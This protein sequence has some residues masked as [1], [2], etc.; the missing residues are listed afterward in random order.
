MLGKN[1][2]MR[3]SR[4]YD[5]SKGV[6]QLPN[7]SSTPITHTGT[8]D[9]S[10]SIALHHVL[11][12]PHF[13]Y[14]LPSISKFVK[15]L[16]CCVT[17]SPQFCV[18]MT[19]WVGIMGIGRQRNGPYHL[20]SSSLHTPAQWAFKSFTNNVISSCN[21]SVST[22]ISIKK[23]FGIKG[24]VIFLCQDWKIYIF[25]LLI[26][27]CLTVI[28]VPKLN[29]N[30]SHFPSHAPLNPPLLSIW[31]TWMFGGHFLHKPT[32]VNDTFSPLL[33]TYTCHLGLS[34]AFQ[35]LSISHYQ[36]FSQSCSK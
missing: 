22:D 9:I 4:T 7:G 16:H 15:D 18:F 20:D 2:V 34:F 32:M 5:G 14:N 27:F 26:L 10:G 36:N 25:Y 31:F 17:F 30:N 35:S 13:N 1:G 24:L 33:T 21:P 6:I 12:V 8:I 23:H 28:F 3:D 19:C 29:K 11:L